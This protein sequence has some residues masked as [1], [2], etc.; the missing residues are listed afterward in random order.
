MNTQSNALIVMPRD[1]DGL[2]VTIQ[3]KKKKKKKRNKYFKLIHIIALNIELVTTVN[4]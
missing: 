1:V 4:N 3:N 2:L